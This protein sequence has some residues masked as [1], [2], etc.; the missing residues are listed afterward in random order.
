MPT[1][2]VTIEDGG[3]VYRYDTLEVHFDHLGGFG[4]I[5]SLVD[6]GSMDFDP[7]EI[8]PLIE[9]LQSIKADLKEAAQ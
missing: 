8:D 9:M 4:Q 5:R 7:Q 2:K 3:K 6:N 1:I